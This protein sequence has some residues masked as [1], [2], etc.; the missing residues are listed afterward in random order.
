MALFP[1]IFLATIISGSIHYTLLDE[2]IL[3]RAQR[4]TGPL[5]T[6]RYGIISSFM[7]GRNSIISQFLV[8]KQH[9]NFGFQLFP[10]FSLI[11]SLLNYIIINPFFLVDINFSSTLLILLS[12]LSIV[13]IIFLGF[14]GCSKYSIFLV[15]FLR[16]SNIS[17]TMIFI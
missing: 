3:G 12:G 7:N 13:F 10:I 14:P 9:L 2:S 1:L 16:L 15:C 17:F 6:G 11:F 4:R 5:N 8:P